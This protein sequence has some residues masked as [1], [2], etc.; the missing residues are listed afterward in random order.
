MTTLFSR[1]VRRGEAR[2]TPPPSTVSPHDIPG[3][4]LSFF[5]GGQTPPRTPRQGAHTHKKTPITCSPLVGEPHPQHYLC[6]CR[7]CGGGGPASFTVLNSGILRTH[8]LESWCVVVSSHSCGNDL[9]T[10]VLIPPTGSPQSNGPNQKA[11]LPMMRI[12]LVLM[13]QG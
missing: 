4:S 3:L 10:M 8:K 12:M 5:L 6:C 11:R 2:G 7:C 9:C 13:R 1:H